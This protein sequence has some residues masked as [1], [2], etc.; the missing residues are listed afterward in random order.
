MNVPLLRPPSSRP[1]A[2][3][4]IE[5][6]YLVLGLALVFRYRWVLDD[7]GVYWR[8]V[9]NWLFLHRGL[10]YNQG[11]WAEGYS[12]PLWLL[13]LAL[14]RLTRL[15]YWTLT[16]ITG[17]A[18]YAAFWCAAV[19]VNRALKGGDVGST[20]DVPLAYLCANYG[21]ASYFTSGSES[22]L[23][24][25]AA[26]GVA[27]FAL[28]P[29]NRWLAVALGALPL[30]RNEFVV[31]AAALVVCTRLRTGRTPW[32]LLGSTMACG[33]AWLLFRV[34]YYA[35]LFPTTY[36][37]KDK[38]SIAHGLYY[39]GNAVEPYGLVAYLVGFGLMLLLLARSR[40]VRLFV[41]ARAVMWVT[42]LAAV[43]YVV[44]VGGDMMHYR[45][46]A[47][48][49]CLAALSMGGIA[50][51]WL[52]AVG[53][54]G[55]ALRATIGVV[56]AGASLAAYPSFLSAHPLS[57]T[58]SRTL[59]DGISD[60]AIHR[61]APDLTYAIDRRAQDRDLLA[62]YATSDGGHTAVKAHTGCVNMFWDFRTRY[63]HGYG[64]TEPLLA[65]L[66]VPEE[67]PGHKDAL[68]ELATELAKIRGA[69][70]PASE[71][72]DRALS[73]GKAPRWAS[74]NVDQVRQVEARMYNAHHLFANA[75]AALRRIG[76]IAP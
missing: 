38:V 40:E 15:D 46:L 12:S 16:M 29:D 53:L 17:L 21:V 47:F 34:W 74:K 41:G 10:V 68:R 44:K 9:D 43:A 32:T 67:R 55:K 25:L 14:L 31:P 37:L 72:L 26:A 59:D 4:T 11:E 70:E 28:R 3:S 19:A 71:A 51:R 27:L 42:A 65:R 64:L 23:M 30:V 50:E 45:L 6:L 8:Y 24:Q 36:Y 49:F 66:A 39:V 35:D 52:G 33:G 60:A 18:T 54:D 7:S 48:P 75:L 63:V 73:A 13:V 58:E 56:V 61:H 1:S 69:T 76:P 20:I 22:P 57:G 62:A 5:W 2:L